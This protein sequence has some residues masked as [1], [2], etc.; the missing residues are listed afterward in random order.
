VEKPQH[1]ASGIIKQRIDYATDLLSLH[2]QNPKRYPFL[3]ESLAQATTQNTPQTST[4]KNTRFDILFAEPQT[5]LTLY[6]ADLQ[7]RDFL[8]ELDLQY[9]QLRTSLTTADELPFS[10]GWFLFFA[11]E[12]AAQIEPTLRLPAHPAQRPLACAVRIP[13]AIIRDHVAQQSWLV[14]EAEYAHL[15]DQLLDDLQQDKPQPTPAHV[16]HHIVEDDPEQYLTAVR[17][18]KDYIAAGDIFQANLSRQWQTPLPSTVTPAQLYQRLR[19][20]N[21]APFSALACWD[22]WAIISSSPERL[23]KV[24]SQRGISARPI[25]GTRPRGHGQSQALLAHPKERAE[26]LMLIDLARND[27][28]RVC[29][30]GSIR[31]DELMRLESYRHVHHIVSNVSGKLSES[32]TPGEVIRAVFPG[33]TISGCPKVRC[34]QIIAELE[35]S[36]RGAYT[37]SLGY[38]NRDGSMDLNIL[39]RSF[40]QHANTLTWRAGAGIVHDSDP[41]KELAETRAKARGLSAALA[42]LQP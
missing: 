16:P 22:D 42:P 33:G 5:H 7:S 38:L 18:A 13:A 10:G 8:A 17:Q 3:L 29:I 14:V 23:V 6:Q 9:T 34:M 19:R 35:K 2:A 32:V 31:V 36:P 21:P 4:H 12:F 24:D 27:L 37:G 41:Q 26:H 28:G 40:T 1:A 39:I 20:S 25:A 11:Y 30:P 15:R